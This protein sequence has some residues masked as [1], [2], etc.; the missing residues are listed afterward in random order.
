[1]KL[2]ISEKVLFTAFL[3]MTVVASIGVMGIVFLIVWGGEKIK[4]N[5]NSKKEKTKG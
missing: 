1:M 2:T 3:I 4:I 5:G